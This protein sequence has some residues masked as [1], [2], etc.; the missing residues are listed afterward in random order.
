MPLHS[1]GRNVEYS[2]CSTLFLRAPGVGVYSRFLNDGVPLIALAAQFWADRL[3]I[4]SHV[5][6]ERYGELEVL[7]VVFGS[8]M[9]MVPGSISCFA[10]V[11]QSIDLPCQ[12]NQQA[13]D[14]LE[15]QAVVSSHQHL[16]ADHELEAI[17]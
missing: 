8:A 12:D 1:R 6:G 11:V 13:L 9:V 17:A 5:H 7:R 10:V 16:V 14:I 2:S 15:L 4:V 3:A